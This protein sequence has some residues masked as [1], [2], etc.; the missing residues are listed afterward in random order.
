MLYSN[1][2]INISTPDNALKSYS[3]KIK[4][5]VFS[6]TFN[7]ETVTVL[8]HAH[9]RSIT[10]DLGE[11]DAQVEVD[12]EEVNKITPNAQDLVQPIVLINDP[13]PELYVNK[14]NQ[15]G[16]RQIT[17]TSN[18]K[19]KKLKSDDLELSNNSES[20]DSGSEF[21]ISSPQTTKMKQ[22]MNSVQIGDEQVEV[23]DQQVEVGDEQ[24]DDSLKI[25][26][27][28]ISSYKRQSNSK[29]LSKYFNSFKI[30]SNHIIY[31]SYHAFKLYIFAEKK[32]SVKGML[33]NFASQEPDK[34]FE[35]FSQPTNKYFKESISESLLEPEPF[36]KTIEDVQ[37]C[38]KYLA[39]WNT[40]FNNCKK[41][42]EKQD[43]KM[44]K[45][46]YSLTDVFFSIIKI[47]HQEQVKDTS[48]K[49]NTNTWKGRKN[50]QILE[51]KF[52]FFIPKR[53]LV[54]RESCLIKKKKVTSSV[55]LDFG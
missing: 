32:R 20:E 53:I 48:S 46:I 40:H 30:S 5:S 54:E 41:A 1:N 11:T 17:V 51:Y 55:I 31:N 6:V 16:K 25:G 34:I 4:K 35:I 2:E 28:T 29:I 15:K 26:K 14:G 47:C 44:L 12:D 49:K 27:K 3:L 42:I 7:N 23:G 24:V 39:I 10:V 43:F 37:S 36:P 52:T 21:D 19:G 8:S 50:E 22:K 13:I 9:S 45:L 18:R 38:F 33:S